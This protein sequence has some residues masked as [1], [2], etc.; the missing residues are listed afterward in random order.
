MRID[1]TPE[2]CKICGIVSQR[3]ELLEACKNFHSMAVVSVP[4]GIDKT[5]WNHCFDVLETAINNAENPKIMPPKKEFP[6]E[7]TIKNIE[8]GKPSI[9]DDYEIDE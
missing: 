9:C 8:R 5:H 7:L 3:D 1:R 2:I 4:P 6:V